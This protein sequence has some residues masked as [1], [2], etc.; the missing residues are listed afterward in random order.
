[1]RQSQ[2]LTRRHILAAMAMSAFG[3]VNN[4]SV[5]TRAKSATFVLV[6]G[7]W[8]GGWT[9]KKV[10]PLLQAAGHQAFTPTLTGLGERVHLS[11]PQVDL[12]T[13]TQDIISMLEYE[14]LHD[15][16]L[17]GH[18]Y[19]GMVIAGVG[20][21]ATA[22]LSQLVYLDAFLPENGKALKDYSIVTARSIEQ[23]RAKGDEWRLPMALTMADLGVTDPA[24][25][26]WMSPRI[27]DQPYKTFT[28]PVE[29]PKDAAKKLRRT[30]IQTSKRPSFNEAA[31]RARKQGFHYYDLF[32]GG[33]AAMVT[34]PQELV[35]ILLELV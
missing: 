34:K 21:K 35:K 16:I 22:R 11:G 31:E 4:A 29:L 30:Y 7:G 33:H 6:H 27:V 20:E 12:N 9:W 18:S 5:V 17:V 32:S 10:I 8:H 23:M 13:H 19:G 24:D 3:G 25:I 28:Q 1:M 15:V 26:A 14:D 2:T